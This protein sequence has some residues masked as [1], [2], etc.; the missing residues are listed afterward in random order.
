M[1]RQ[2]SDVL[3]EQLEEML[4]DPI[5]DADDALE[6]AMVAGLLARLDPE[7]GALAT[8]QTWLDEDGRDLLDEAFMMVDLEPLVEAIDALTPDDDDEAVEEAVLDVDELVA[9][10]IWCGHG[11]DVGALA[12]EVAKAARALP[13]AF[14]SLA[15]IGADLAKEPAVAE[16]L[17]LYDFW[18][19]IADAAEWADN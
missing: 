17:S 1:S 14:V 15:D 18:F 5:V 6:V 4:N 10:A 7:S 2:E 12:R 11:S 16:H 8:A 13:E 9:A 3:A 19:A